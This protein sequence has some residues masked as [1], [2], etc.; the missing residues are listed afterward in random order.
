MS[1][2]ERNHNQQMLYKLGKK[3]NLNP[4]IYGCVSDAIRKHHAGTQAGHQL[5]R[6]DTTVLPL[7]VELYQGVHNFIVIVFFLNEGKIRFLVTSENK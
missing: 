5:G 6:D 3:E 7:L 4:V 2:Y 1:Y